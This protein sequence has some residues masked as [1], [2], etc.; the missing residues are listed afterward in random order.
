M[1][2]GST[3]VVQG[4]RVSD[5]AAVRRASEG[6]ALSEVCA[7]RVRRGCEG[8]DVCANAVRATCE[9]GEVVRR[10]CAKSRGWC[11]ESGCA[12]VVRECGVVRCCRRSVAGVRLPARFSGI[13]T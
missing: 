10:G 11:D 2:R 5:E 9:P 6:V 3:K 12:K 1:R 13:E 8:C 4:S 7:T